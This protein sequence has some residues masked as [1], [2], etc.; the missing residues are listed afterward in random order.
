[1]NG[2]NEYARRPA[3]DILVK[4]H[5]I[6]DVVES[7]PTYCRLRLVDRRIVIFSHEVS[8]R[9]RLPLGDQRPR[10]LRLWPRNEGE[11]SGLGHDPLAT[12]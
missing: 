9:T 7:A 12:W 4:V 10:K 1:M 8:V 5:V 2:T 11:S 3:H 6:Y